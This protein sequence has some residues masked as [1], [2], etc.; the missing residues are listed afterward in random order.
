MNRNSHQFRCTADHISFCLPSDRRTSG[1]KANIEDPVIVDATVEDDGISILS[2]LFEDDVIDDEKMLLDDFRTLQIAFDGLE[3]SVEQQK[4][5]LVDR[6]KAEFERSFAVEVTELSKYIGE[7]KST[8]A[9]LQ[10][11]VNK[12]SFLLRKYRRIHKEQQSVTLDVAIV[13]YIN[14]L[15]NSRQ[16][17]KLLSHKK[18]SSSI[19]KLH[20]ST[21][22]ATLQ[23]V[24]RK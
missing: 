9:S 3:K 17:Y 22:F 23:S 13:T 18:L 11:K 6:L 20:A 10:A 2:Q 5:A 19:A 4:K 12:Q 21:K 15:V 24:L 14:Y 7:L 16:Q 1:K 8:I